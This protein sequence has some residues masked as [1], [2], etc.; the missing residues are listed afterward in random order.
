MTKKNKILLTLLLIFFVILLALI[1]M[2]KT[3]EFDYNIYKLVISIKSDTITNLLKLITS[4]GDTLCIIFIILLCFIIF[5]NKFYPKIITINILITV[6]I[7]QVLKHIIQRP[8]PNF[9]HL[10]EENGFS[11]PSGHS[12]AAFSFYGLFI[13][14]IY[15]SNINKKIKILLITLLS[16]LIIM[17]GLSRVYLGVH[18]ITDI[19]GGFTMS[20][21]IL[22]SFTSFVKKYLKN[23]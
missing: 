21:I 15:K 4:L 18:Y 8:R 3:I 11:F 7:N 10:V 16:L 22:I 13:Y 19:I 5:K 1:K 14:L 12:M 2:N 6:F 17:I 20:L 9:T 23:V